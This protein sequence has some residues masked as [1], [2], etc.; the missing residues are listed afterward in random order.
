MPHAENNDAT[1]LTAVIGV[2]GALFIAI[3]GATWHLGSRLAR[4][5]GRL[6]YLINGTACAQHREEMHKA[7]RDETYNH[8][9]R[10]HVATGGSVPRPPA[11]RG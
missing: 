8:E 7:I 9:R 3:V 2:G 11:A 1:M 5:E 10:H 6:E 4:V